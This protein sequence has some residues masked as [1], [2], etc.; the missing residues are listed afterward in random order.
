M[1]SP[2]RRTLWVSAHSQQQQPRSTTQ[3]RNWRLLWHIH[4]WLSCV[5]P[6]TTTSSSSLSVSVSTGLSLRSR[7]RRIVICLAERTAGSPTCQPWIYTRSVEGVAT[8]QSADGVTIFE[9][10]ETDGTSIPRSLCESKGGA[11][12][13]DD[14]SGGY[15]IVGV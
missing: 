7:L 8:G 2:H 1:P 9:N 5:G 14:G 3:P 15:M 13:R 6:A 11:A 4:P 10:I 12:R